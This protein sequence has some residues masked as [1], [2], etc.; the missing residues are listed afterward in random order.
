MP[1]LNQSKFSA[2]ST[3]ALFLGLALTAHIALPRPSAAAGGAQVTEFTL[4]NGLRFVVIPDHRVPVVTHQIWYAAGAADEQPDEHGIAHY[5]EHMMFKGTAAYPKGEFDK[6]VASRGGQQNA[7]TWATGTMYW[8]RVPKPALPQLMA[9]ESDRMVNL[10]IADE[11]VASERAVVMEELRRQQMSTT[12]EIGLN[13]RAALYGGHPEG[14]PTIGTGASI[15]AFT[16]AKAQGFYQRFYDPSRAT[17]I[18]AG[19]VTE[20]EVRALA[21][22]TYAQVQP[23]TGLSP[24]VVVPLPA[25]AEPQRIEASHERATSVLVSRSYLMAG[26]SIMSRRDAHAMTLFAN[27]AGSG[28]TSRLHRKLIVEEAK[29]TSVGCSFTLGAQSSSFSCDAWSRIGVLASELEASFTRTLEDL[30]SGGITD[31]EFEEIRDRFLA[32][33][34][35]RKDSVASRADSYGGL[36]AEGFSIADVEALEADI[37]SLRRAEV[38]SVARRVLRDSRVVTGILSPKIPVAAAAPALTAN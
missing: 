13:M 29:A 24:H 4:D 21:G 20:A 35:Y 16:G 7:R 3:A 36:L 27:I 11:D 14:R 1:M 33:G 30:A 5:L 34:A 22:D 10:H 17:V 6:F 12:S 32:T 2:W 9:M 26:L 19:D 18:V 31:E 38:E 28:M 15:S 8:Q 25:Q 23:R 37:A